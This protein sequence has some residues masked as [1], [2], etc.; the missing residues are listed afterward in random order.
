MKSS[1]YLK[2]FLVLIIFAAA[3]SFLIAN[4]AASINLRGNTLY[5]DNIQTIENVIDFASQTDAAGEQLIFT[6]ES[7]E[8][9]QYL[10]DILYGNFIRVY[11]VENDELKLIYEND[12]T[13]VKP[14]EIDIGFIDH[15][16]VLDVYVGAITE[17]EY[18]PLEKRPFF[19]Q[20]MDGYLT[21]KWTGSYIGF[22]P[23]VSIALNDHTN[24]GIDEVI[25]KGLTKE[26]EVT[27]EIYRWG[28]FGF[29]RID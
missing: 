23:M 19:F 21:R 9:D 11:T 5:Y 20:W 28:N 14:W 1:P 27:S 18:Y 24:D 17:T 10:N 25:K 4:N 8:K 13:H 6:I 2:Y 7:I 15:D 26:G 29:Y 16:D 22:T 12:F 3:I